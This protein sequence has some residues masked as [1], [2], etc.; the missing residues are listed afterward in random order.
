MGVGVEEIA[1]PPPEPQPER[2]MMFKVRRRESRR[3]RGRV[4]GAVIAI[5]QK[6]GS[7]LSGDWF[8]LLAMT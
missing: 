6:R 4:L 1:P 7:N 8:A 2:E 5:R 3:R